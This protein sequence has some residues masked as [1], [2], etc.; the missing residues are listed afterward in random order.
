M[1][2]TL[3]NVRTLAVKGRSGYTRGECALAK[4]QQLR[5]EI[6]GLQETRQGETPFKAAGYRVFCCG[7]QEE[8]Q[9]RQGLRGVRL[10]VRESMC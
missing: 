7:Q 9:A 4:V 8:S 1:V 2:V 3:Y 6:V 5:C 10:A